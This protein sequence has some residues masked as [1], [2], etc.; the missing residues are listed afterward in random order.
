[1]G[2]GWEQSATDCGGKGAACNILR[3]EGN[4][5][6]QTAGGQGTACNRLWVGLGLLHVSFFFFRTFQKEIRWIHMAKRRK[7]SEQSWERTKIPKAE[8]GKK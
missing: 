7:N 4:N 5:L 6:Q 2:G 3:G 1:M 8:S